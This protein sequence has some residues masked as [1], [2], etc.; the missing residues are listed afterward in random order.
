MGKRLEDMT[1]EELWELFPITIT[2]HNPHWK[3]WADEEIDNLSKIMSSY[4]TKIS[5]IGSTAIPYIQAK[6]IIDIL[7]E[8]SNNFNWNTIK[9]LLIHTGYICMSECK[10][11]M[12]FNKGYTIDGYAERVFHVHIHLPGDNDEILF[13]DFLIAHADVAKEYEN[14]K[15]NLLPKYRNN[16]DGYTAAKSQFIQ[17]VLSMSR[18]G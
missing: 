12:S 7:V 5:H 15:L 14:L 3:L 18:N 4:S 9:K 17:R 2:A 6:P 16:R 1:L 11:R 8:V 10:N 13:R